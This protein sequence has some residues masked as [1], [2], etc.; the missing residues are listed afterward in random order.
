M[1]AATVKAAVAA[2]Q[3]N[4]AVD[5]VGVAFTGGLDTSDIPQLL[6]TRSG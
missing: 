1:A 6:G 4:A 2:F 3:Y 5:R